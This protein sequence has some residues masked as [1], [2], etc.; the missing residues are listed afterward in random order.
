MIPIDQLTSKVIAHNM[1]VT[2]PHEVGLI[3]IASFLI[4]M[5]FVMA[6]GIIVIG[7][8]RKFLREN[9]LIE[10]YANWKHQQKIKELY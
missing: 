4:G 9:K 6:A 1:L 7:S 2:T 3:M 8:Y 5:L 10:K